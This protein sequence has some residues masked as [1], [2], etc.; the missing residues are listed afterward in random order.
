MTQSIDVSGKRDVIDSYAGS[1]DTSGGAMY[2]TQVTSDN[3]SKGLSSGKW[4]GW[5][6]NVCDREHKRGIEWS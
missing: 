1:E 4:D 2:D 5:N 6:A 3:V